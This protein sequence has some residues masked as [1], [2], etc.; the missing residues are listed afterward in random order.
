[1]A[2]EGKKLKAEIG[3]ELDSFGTSREKQKAEMDYRTTD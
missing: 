2:G 1:M 3:H